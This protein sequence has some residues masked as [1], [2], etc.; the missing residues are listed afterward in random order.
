MDRPDSHEEVYEIAHR[1]FLNGHQRLIIGSPELAIPIFEE[2]FRDFKPRLLPGL[3]SLT[4][5]MFDWDTPEFLRARELL[6]WCATD[7]ALAI[8]FSGGDKALALHWVRDAV[9]YN[10]IDAKAHE[11]YGRLLLAVGK[12]EL[13]RER[14]EGALTINRLAARPDPGIE[15]GIKQ[16]LRRLDG[17]PSWWPFW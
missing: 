4:S 15:K 11:V 9:L 8:D 2:I 10:E 16:L 13:A 6:G 14:L 5:L 1:L 12:M 7:Y 17:K 3:Q